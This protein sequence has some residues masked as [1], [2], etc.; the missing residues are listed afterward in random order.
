[1]TEEQLREIEARFAAPDPMTWGG[2]QKHAL[3]LVAAYRE[4]RDLAVWLAGDLEEAMLAWPA[5]HLASL[6]KAREAGL[7]E[8]QG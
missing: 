4:L 3:A 5:V 2:A 6:T 8:A 1:M 7:L